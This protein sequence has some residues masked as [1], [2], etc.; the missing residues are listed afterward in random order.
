MN[1]LKYK[2][3][4]NNI[5]NGKSILERFCNEENITIYKELNVKYYF[6]FKRFLK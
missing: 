5:Y 1:N 3:Y 4:I 6:Y 2:D